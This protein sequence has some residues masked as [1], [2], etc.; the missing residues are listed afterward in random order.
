VN[1]DRRRHQLTCIRATAVEDRHRT[2]EG[3]R[4]WTISRETHAG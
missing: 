2:G 3:E 4:K 1:P